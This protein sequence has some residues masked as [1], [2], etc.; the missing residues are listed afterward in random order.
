MAPAPKKSSIDSQ[1]DFADKAK[2]APLTAEQRASL[3]AALSAIG[4]PHALVLRREEAAELATLFGRPTNAEGL[5]QLYKRRKGPPHYRAGRRTE[6]R[7]EDI[8]RWIINPA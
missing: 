2:T 7:P 1:T 8:V 6:Y 4:R 3:Q 5:K